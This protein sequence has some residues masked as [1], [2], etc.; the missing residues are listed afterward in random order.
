MWPIARYCDGSHFVHVTGHML[1]TWQVTWPGLAWHIYINFISLL[2]FPYSCDRSHVGHV[3]GHV[4]WPMYIIVAFRSVSLLSLFPSFLFSTCSS[5]GM[6]AIASG[7]LMCGFLN[8]AV[9]LH[10]VT[11][12]PPYNGDAG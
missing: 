3:T 10:I 5:S 12:M 6:P 9:P 11:D 8:R 4:T 2:N 1:V 7:H